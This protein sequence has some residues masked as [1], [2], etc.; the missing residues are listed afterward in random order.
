MGGADGVA[1]GH[2]ELGRYPGI[3]A[4]PDGEL[5]IKPSYWEPGWAGRR[6]ELKVLPIVP[7][8]K[9]LR[10]GVN[11][12]LSHISGAMLSCINSPASA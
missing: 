6:V 11:S 5:Q 10:K 9:F 1:W 2:R 7:S 4:L 8:A 12:S 3:C